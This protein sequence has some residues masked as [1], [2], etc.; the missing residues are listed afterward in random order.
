MLI[1]WFTVGAQALNFAILVWLLKRV[2]YQPILDAIDAREKRIAAELA[3]ALSKQAEAQKARDDFEHKNKELDRTRATLMRQAQDEA[4]AERQRLLEEARI[5]AA[6]LSTRQLQM[7]REDAANLKH[8]I[9]RRVQQEV[10]AIARKTLADLAATSLEERLVEVFAGQLRQMDS[11]TKECFAAALKAAAQTAF[12]H[13]AFVLPDAQRATIQVALNQTLSADIKLHFETAP[14]LVSGIE[15]TAGGQKIAWSI[16][17]YLASME[18]S[19]DELLGAPS[20]A[21]PVVEIESKQTE[22]SR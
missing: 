17:N 20:A 9:G 4:N 14:E 16:R 15:I 21:R 11:Q 3:D 22:A 8:A 5:A 6:A 10:F 18:K 7:L 13:S 19:V 12:V 1:D 2:L